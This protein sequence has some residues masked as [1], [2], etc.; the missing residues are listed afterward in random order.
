MC[1]HTYIFICSFIYINNNTHTHTESEPPIQ[2]RLNVACQQA[3]KKCMVRRSVIQRVALKFLSS[4]SSL[5]LFAKGKDNTRLKRQCQGLRSMIGFCSIGTFCTK[6]F[7]QS[8]IHTCTLR[9]VLFLSITF[10]VVF[11]RLRNCYTVYYFFKLRLHSFKESD[12]HLL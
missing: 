9:T 3:W 11:D 4:F 2:K 5:F 1:A 7:K 6:L 12:I 10:I 8:D